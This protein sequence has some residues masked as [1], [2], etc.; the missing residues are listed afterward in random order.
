MPKN[1]PV[2]QD[3]ATHIAA[4][5]NVVVPTFHGEWSFGTGWGKDV[6]Y[7]GDIQKYLLNQIYA[8][9]KAAGS[10][11]IPPRTYW[12]D[13]RPGQNGDKHV[14]AQIDD[15]SALAARLRTSDV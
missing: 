12:P 4:G 1:D 6:P 5:A 2:F 13:F 11:T 7:W 15:L 8:L 14:L 10:V 3:L 9:G